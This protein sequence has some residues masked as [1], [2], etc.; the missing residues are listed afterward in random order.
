MRGRVNRASAAE[1]VDLGSIPDRVKPK[2]T[3]IGISQRSA[4]KRTVCTMQPPP[5]VVNR[6]AGGSLTRRSEASTLSAD[7]GNL[8]NKM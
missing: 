3:K 2:N 7:H 5:C 1:T 6:R 4:I 8:E